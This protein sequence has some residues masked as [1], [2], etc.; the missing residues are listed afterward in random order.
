M[1]EAASAEETAKKQAT[2]EIAEVTE[3]ENVEVSVE[4]IVKKAASEALN[5]V[6]SVVEIAKKA[7]TEVVVVTEVVIAKKAASEEAKTQNPKL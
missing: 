2:E 6:V 3:A 5:A 7:A 1:K 4:A